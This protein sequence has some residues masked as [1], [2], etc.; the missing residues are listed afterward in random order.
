LDEKDPQPHRV[1]PLRYA[2]P[3]FLLT[4]DVGGVYHLSG[5]HGRSSWMSDRYARYINLTGW[6]YVI[7]STPVRIAFYGYDSRLL[8]ALNTKYIYVPPYIPWQYDLAPTIH[9]EQPIVPG[10]IAMTTWTID[11]VSKKVFYESPPSSFSLFGGHLPQQPLYLKTA[12]A[13]QPD[14]WD[15]G[16]DGVQ[17]E[18]YLQWAD[19]QPRELLFSQY[20]DPKHNP[21]EQHWIPVEIDLSKYIGKPTLD[22]T[23]SADTKVSFTFVTKPGPA[24][25]NYYDWAGWAEPVLETPPVDT[26]KLELLFDGPN[27][28]YYNKQALPR[29]W[30]VHWVTQVPEKDIEA[31]EARLIADDFEPAIEAVV[32]G[33]LPGALGEA[34]PSDRVEVTSYAAHRVKIE[35]NLAQPGLLVLSD[36]FYPG[37][38]AYVDGVERPIYATNLIMRGVYLKEG[39]HRVI[40]VYKPVAF[41]RGLYI[42]GGTSLLILLGLAWQWRQSCRRETLVEPQTEE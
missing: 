1:L 26:S 28:V 6:R 15:K 37:W 40:F 21:A 13:M 11:N 7:H 34:S 41:T 32:E 12:I 36:M 35:V 5:V 24:N 20:I 39:K 25:D 4:E 18:I 42:S 17:F 14:S 19:E 31:V 2:W 8:D 27:K 29:V 30:V 10:A 38:K 16:G 22:F 3:S 33:E 9:D 23:Q